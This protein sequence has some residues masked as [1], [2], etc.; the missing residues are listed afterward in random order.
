MSQISSGGV[1]IKRTKK[2]PD[3]AAIRWLWL[4][5]KDRSIPLQSLT[6]AEYDVLDETSRN[7]EVVYLVESADE[8][9][10]I[11]MGK[12][13]GTSFTTDDTLTFEDEVLG[14][15][16][17]TKLVTSDEYDNL[18]EEEK[19]SDVAWIITDDNSNGGSGGVGEEI[20]STEEVRIGTWI[21]GKPLYRRVIE[22]ITPSSSGSSEYVANF[23]SSIR[24][25][26]YYGIV[27]LNNSARLVAPNRAGSEYIGLYASNESDIS[28]ITT[29]QSALSKPIFVVGEYTKTTD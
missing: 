20:Y 17:P 13:V 8:L 25:V 15:A 16:V 6:K 18:S 21:D 27:H 29:W 4:A 5:V 11:Y 22:G 26:H 24:F 7:A 3:S 9:R 28:C 19:M 23:G 10:F 1:Q 12:T 14:V 2:V